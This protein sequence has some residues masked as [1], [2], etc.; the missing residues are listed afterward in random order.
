MQ[1]FDIC[2][3]VKVSQNYDAEEF[4]SSIIISHKSFD[5]SFCEQSIDEMTLHVYQTLINRR[6]LVV[7]DDMWST[8]VWDHVMNLFPD[9]DNGSRIILTTRLSDVANYVDPSRHY[10][11]IMPLMDEYQ[12]WNLLQ[13]KV[14][15]AGITCPLE[16]KITGFKIARSCRGLPLAI[17]L[18]AGLLSTVN[19]DLDVWKNISRRINFFGTTEYKCI[20]EIL[21]LSYTNLPNY[22][23]PCFLYMGAFPEDYEIHVS[24][25]IKL[26]VAEGFL[27]PIESKSLEEW[28]EECLEI[29]SRRNL[30][31]VNKRKSDG[32]TKSYI[33]H[34]LVRQMCIRKAKNEKFLYTTR[35]ESGSYY[36][37]RRVSISSN[38]D[39]FRYIDGSDIHTIIS[40]QNGG[41]LLSYLESFRLLRVLDDF[42][43]KFNM[44]PAEVSN[45]FHLRFLAFSYTTRDSKF[46]IP[47]LILHLHNLQTLMVHSD[48][49]SLIQPKSVYLPIEIWKMANLRHLVSFVLG[50]FPDPPAETPPLENLQTL[51]V[52]TNFKCTEEMLLMIP[53]LKKLGIF[54][55]GERESWPNYQLNNLVNLSQLEKLSIT[56]IDRVGDSRSFLEWFVSPMSLKKLTLRGCKIRWEDFGHISWPNLQVLKLRNHACEGDIW[57]TTEDKYPQLKVL[58]IE[59]TNL[60]IWEAESGHFPALET[61]LLYGCDGLREI[62]EDI[63]NIMTLE[64]IE[65][66]GRNM[67]LLESANRIREEQESFGNYGLHVRINRA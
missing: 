27:E 4:L 24:K 2:A 26:C 45:L 35:T 31:M 19:Q 15:P 41:A 55:D 48:T 1:H 66:D 54:Y 12:S 62:P 3:W 7:V 59:T 18:T 67:S 63:G 16:L 5:K 32:K 53:N 47:V 57:K 11:H 51:S 46:C 29:L 44:F 56:V 9:N 23:R 10:H 42:K 33:L 39:F 17:V 21:L 13:N 40:F 22:L 58:M 6:Y 64:L 14:F 49:R 50:P 65:V 20:E 28:A 37:H 43:A 34:D 30:V 60:K 8:D 25:L 52:V 61:S 38:S 36:K